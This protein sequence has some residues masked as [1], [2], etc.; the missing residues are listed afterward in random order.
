[1]NNKRQGCIGILARLGSKRL[2]G[3]H[4]L[5]INDRP[6]ISYLIQRI[7]N[8]FSKEISNKRLEIFILTGNQ[9]LNQ[10]LADV[11]F[12]YEISVYFGHD[13]NIP[14]RMFNLLTKKKFD[15]IISI[16]GD[17]IL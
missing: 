13:K 8:E 6:V 7:K 1:M 16:D 11:A 4:L 15:F 3:K 2:K 5:D 10:K 14:L 12:K 9:K 17:D